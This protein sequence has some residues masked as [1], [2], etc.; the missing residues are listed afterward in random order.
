MTPAGPVQAPAYDLTCTALY[1]SHVSQTFA[2]AVGDAFSTSELSAYEWAQFCAATD[3]HPT[4]VRKE[5]ERSTRLIRNKLPALQQAVSR[6]GAIPEVV[7]KISEIVEK[8]CQRQLDLA[9]HIRE[10]MGIA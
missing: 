8:Q 2:M 6:D 3:T 9:P 7:R 10:M 1:Q 4:Q 5:I